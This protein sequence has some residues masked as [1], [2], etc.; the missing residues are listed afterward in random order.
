MTH[1]YLTYTEEAGPVSIPVS[2]RRT[3][4]LG[5]VSVLPKDAQLLHVTGGLQTRLTRSHL[6]RETGGNQALQK[7]GGPPRFPSAGNRP[8]R[9]PLAGTCSMEALP[10][11]PEEDRTFASTAPRGAAEK[12]APVAPEETLACRLPSHL[13]G[14]P[15]PQ[16]CPHPGQ[17]TYQGPWGKRLT[18]STLTSHLQ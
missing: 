11:P 14:E 9:A 16:P 3:S 13:A 2:Q 6:R 15:L 17:A 4:R 5:E 12:A 8:G 18:L 10:P 1:H 7:D